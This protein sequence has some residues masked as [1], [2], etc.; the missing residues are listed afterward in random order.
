MNYDVD[1]MIKEA[2]SGKDILS[3]LSREDAAKINAILNDNAA[4]SKLLSSENAKA[5]MEKIKNG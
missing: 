1:K 4:L 5:L 2:K 3:K